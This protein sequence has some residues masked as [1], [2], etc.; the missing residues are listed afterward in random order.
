MKV[1]VINCGSSSIKYE[2]FDVRDCVMLAT[3]LV[4]KIGSA[5]GRLRQRRRKADGTFEE[6]N[7]T[8]PLAD[9]GEGFDLMA[10]VNRQDQIISDESELFGIGHRVVHGGE[11]FREPALI[12]DEVVAAI[13]RLVPLAP[14]HNPSNLLGIE[15]SRKRF[16]HVPQVAVFDTAFHQT[17]RLMHTITRCHTNYTLSIT[18]ADT[19]FMGHP[20]HTLPKRRRSISADL[21]RR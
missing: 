16:P 14:L 18:F 15:V 21:F 6:R 10:S 4:E 1:A 9:H 2:V 3:G 13:K 20:T 11:V 17:L 8:R 12:D 5:D 19:A 7:D